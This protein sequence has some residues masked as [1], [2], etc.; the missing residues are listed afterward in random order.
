MKGYLMLKP[1]KA[2]YHDF[3]L[4]KYKTLIR[5]I[6]SGLIDGGITSIFSCIIMV[7]LIQ[8]NI[9]GKIL[10][11]TL[12]SYIFS[13]MYNIILVFKYQKTIGKSLLSLKINMVNDKIIYLS[14]SIKRESINIITMALYIVVG[15]LYIIT[16]NLFRSD[17]IMTGKIKEPIYEAISVLLIIIAYS[18]ILSALFNRK[19]RALHDLIAKTIITKEKIQHKMLMIISIILS[20]VIYIIYFRLYGLLKGSF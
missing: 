2:L 16:D 18:E 17:A 4:D 15:V 10:L 8:V 6:F 7:L 9:Y 13:I 1:N 12:L 3:E 5:R 14:D 11:L 19:R 20:I